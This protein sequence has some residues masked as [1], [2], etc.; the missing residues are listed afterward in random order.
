LKDA[1]AMELKLAEEAA[2]LDKVKSFLV[3]SL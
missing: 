1:A 3:F 2:M